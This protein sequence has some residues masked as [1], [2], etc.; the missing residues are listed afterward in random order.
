[1]YEQWRN[2]SGLN[3]EDHAQLLNRRQKLKL[4]SIAGRRVLAVICCRWR[5][6]VSRMNGISAAN[7]AAQIYSLQDS[8]QTSAG[9]GLGFEGKLV[10]IGCNFTEIWAGFLKISV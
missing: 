7:D 2:R 8:N 9:L 3:I 6:Q 4:G 10:Q 1:M 5:A